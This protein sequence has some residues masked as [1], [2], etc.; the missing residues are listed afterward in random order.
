ML[1]E[2]GLLRLSNGVDYFNSLSQVQF[3]FVHPASPKDEE[4]IC[5]N[6]NTNKDPNIDKIKDTNTDANANKSPI[7]LCSPFL[8]QGLG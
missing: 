3:N 7:R 2:D 6:E 8:S 1:N 4:S 5:S